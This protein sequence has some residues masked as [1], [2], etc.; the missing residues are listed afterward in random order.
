MATAIHVFCVQGE[1]KGGRIAR[2]RT[3]SCD[4]DDVGIAEKALK[5]RKPSAIVAEQK[6][7]C[8]SEEDAA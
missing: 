7:R 2:H 5:D 4:L 3:I 1:L 6:P 8:L